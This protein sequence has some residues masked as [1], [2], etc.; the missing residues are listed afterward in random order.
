M[1][2]IVLDYPNRLQVRRKAD[3]RW[4][5]IRIADLVLVASVVLVATASS[6]KVDSS[7]D[8]VL[9]PVAPAVAAQPHPN[10]RKKSTNGLDERSKGDIGQVNR[11]REKRAGGS[12]SSTALALQ[13]SSIACATVGKNF[14]ERASGDGYSDRVSVQIVWN[15]D[16][17]LGQCPAATARPRRVIDSQ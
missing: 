5:T 9:V 12:D 7:S 8:V 6:V 15:E 16:Q 11:A 3:I 14:I 2:A 1:S 10:R 13:S 4:I 17:R